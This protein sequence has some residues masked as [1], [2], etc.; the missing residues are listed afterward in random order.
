[1]MEGDSKGASPMTGPKPAP[2]S[3]TIAWATHWQVILPSVYRYEDQ[4]WIDK[5]FE[6][7]SLRLGSFQQFSQ[8][9]EEWRGDK[10]EGTCVARGHAGDKEIWMVHGQ[11]V[12]AAV[13]CCSLKCSSEIQSDFK[14]DSVFEIF[15]TN[16]FALAVAR[17]LAGF[18][19]GLQGACIY[20]DERI[21]ERAV[22]PSGIGPNGELNFSSMVDY[23]RALGGPELVL[24]KPRRYEPQQEYRF[25]WELDRLDAPHIDIVCPQARQFCRRLS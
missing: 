24:L 17:Q 22:D 20:R 4:V 23:S 7:G 21:I 6:D 16:G 5:F 10:S 19:H 25:I 11:G 13:F 9:D 14:R 1:M 12:S 8:Y 3:V 18:R 2:S 15:D